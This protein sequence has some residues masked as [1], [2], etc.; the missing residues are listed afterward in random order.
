MQKREHGTHR[1]GD[2]S[3]DD[4]HRE[5]KNILRKLFLA[6]ILLSW[7]AQPVCSQGA[8]ASDTMLEHGGLGDCIRFALSH[9]PLIHQ[10]LIDEAI[11]EHAISSKLADWYPQVAFGFNFQH[12]PELPV[13]IVQGS[14]VKLGLQNTSTGQFSLTQTLFN[15]DILLASSTASDVRLASSERTLSS[16]IDVVVNVSKA[17]YAVLVTREQIDLLEE[18]IVRLQQNLA[19]AFNQYKSGVVDKTD[20]QRATIALNNAKAEKSQSEELLKAR[21]ASLKN[22]MGYPPSADLR[23][24]YDT[25]RMERDAILDTAQLLIPENRIE[26]QLLRTQKNLQEANLDYYKWGFLPVLT[27]YG[28]YN[29]SYQNNE[30][31][32]LYGRDYPNSN[33]GLQ[34]SFPI[35]EGG[36]RIQEI[37]Q[38]RLELERIDYD[39]ISLDNAVHS[40]YAAAMANYRSNLNNYHVLKENLALARDVYQTI[41]LQYKAGTKTY[42]DVITAETDLRTAQANETDSLFEVLSSKLDVQKALGTIQYQ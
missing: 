9:Q 25:T 29:L 2:C 12:N 38:A 40:E 11:T 34:L 8:V 33:F 18:D 16:K 28:A 20:Y 13:S 1:D 42:L 15:R 5:K 7:Q 3:D 22:Q 39:L 26:Y 36:K 23:I 41:Q 32:Q 21:S 14:P 6:I 4:R 10:S 19:D 37:S 30:L 27:A 24:E 35:F 17:Y 31:S